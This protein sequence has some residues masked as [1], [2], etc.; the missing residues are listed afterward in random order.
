MVKSPKSAVSAVDLL[1]SRPLPGDCDR[2][3]CVPVFA[4]EGTKRS[5]KGIVG[6]PSENPVSN[7]GRVGHIPEQILVRITN[8]FPVIECGLGDIGEAIMSVILHDFPKELV[9]VELNDR[10]PIKLLREFLQLCLQE[11]VIFADELV[12]IHFPLGVCAV[13]WFIAKRWQ[14]R[15]QKITSPRI[16]KRG[17]R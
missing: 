3:S 6:I 13:V 12:R 2:S 8:H 11:R 14:V 10:D 5:L 17:N 9:Y 15:Y 4:E 7:P 16:V 1:Y